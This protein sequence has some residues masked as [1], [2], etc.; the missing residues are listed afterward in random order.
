M[1]GESTGCT[2]ATTE[3]VLEI[4]LFDPMRTALER[5]PARHR[6]RCAHALRAR[7]RSGHGAARHG[8]RDPADPGAVRRRRRARRSSPAR[9]RRRAGRSASASRSSSGSPGSRWTARRGR[10][11]TC[12]AL[13]FG[14]AEGE[15]A[16]CAVRPP[17]WRHDVTMEADVVEELCR[18]HG[19]DRVPPMPVRR[20]EAV[21]HPALT[22]EQ[23]SA[24]V[25]RRAL[26]ARGLAEA[27]TWSFVSAGDRGALRRRRGCACATRSTPSCR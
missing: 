24:P 10:A 20:T 6:E 8:V 18:L 1:G 12:E 2:D 16:R 23:R 7:R 9:C 25:A 22:P 5:A 11:A 3:V 4:A 19:Y 14:A 13:G 17:T 26:A 15:A 21:G 27:V